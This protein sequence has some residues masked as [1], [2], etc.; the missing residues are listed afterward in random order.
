MLCCSAS[1]LKTPFIQFLFVLPKTQGF[2]R[3]IV[4]P[5]DQAPL[6]SASK[7]LAKASPQ[8]RKISTPRLLQGLRWQNP[9]HRQAR[10]T[11][12]SATRQIRKSAS[13]CKTPLFPSTDEKLFFSNLD[14]IGSGLWSCPNFGINAPVLKHSTR[15]EPMDGLFNRGKATTYRWLSSLNLCEVV[16]GV[17][18]RQQVRQANPRLGPRKLQRKMF[19]KCGVPGNVPEMTVKHQPSNVVRSFRVKRWCRLAYGYG[20]EPYTANQQKCGEHVRRKHRK[21]SDVASI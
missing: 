3:A 18:G 2:S 13:N 6:Q 1:S 16:L 11:G 19:W 20:A 10:H 12:K 5:S 21:I 9:Q 14:Y 7:D 4:A 15:V 17:H 8:V